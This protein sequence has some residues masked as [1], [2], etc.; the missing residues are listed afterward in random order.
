MFI[1]IAPDCP[2][3]VLAKA[4]LE[5]LYP[6]FLTEES[7]WNFLSL[8]QIPVVI[9]ILPCGSLPAFV[10]LWD[11]DPFGIECSQKQLGPATGLALFPR[12]FTE[13]RESCHHPCSRPGGEG[14]WISSPP[15]HQ[16]LSASSGYSLLDFTSVIPCFHCPLQKAKWY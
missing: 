7:S 5:L 6:H 2:P 14:W 16:N 4:S 8:R 1:H 3:Q 11:W 10:S 12:H 13:Q 9:S 15:T